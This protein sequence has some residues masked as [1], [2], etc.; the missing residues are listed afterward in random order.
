MA[1][2]P[3]IDCRFQ[4]PKARRMIGLLAAIVAWWSVPACDAASPQI[5]A[6]RSRLELT[7]APREPAQVLDVLNQLKKRPQQAGARQLNDVS[8]VGQIGGMPNPWNDTHPDF[9][10]FAGQASFFLS[11]SKV[12]VQFANHAKSHG[13]DHQCTFCK[14]LAAKNAHAVA[15]VN[16]V[17][18]DGQTLPIDSR[19]LFALR[20]GQSVVVRGRAELLGGTMLVIHADGLHIRR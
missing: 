1:E 15:V 2:F 5:A 19:E 6:Q 12:A 7:A 10:W 16:L 14:R 11:D 13:G 8:V 20:E 9:P 18:D 4:F 17:G 3:M